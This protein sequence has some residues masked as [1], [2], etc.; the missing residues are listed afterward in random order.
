VFTRETIQAS[1]LS[2]DGK[3]FAV[4]HRCWTLAIHDVTNHT[5]N[6]IFEILDS[7][8]R[9]PTFS[10]DSSRF[11]AVVADRVIHIWDTITHNLLRKS[12][13]HSTDIQSLV[14]SPDGTRIIPICCYS[15]E[16]TL[17]IW[18]I[19]EDLTITLDEHG[20]AAAFFP[21]GMRFLT[22]GHNLRIWDMAST[23]IL[24]STLRASM[25]GS[26]ISISS[27]GA[28][29]FSD[30]CLWDLVNNRQI[31]S[32]VR[33]AT[34]VEFSP[35]CKLA[36][37]CDNIDNI[38]ILDA[39]TGAELYK[40]HLFVK[41][42]SHLSFSPDSTRLLSLSPDELAQVLDLK[43]LPT[44]VGTESQSC[45][46][47]PDCMM[48]QSQSQLQ[49]H[50]GWYHGASGDRL[51]WL[52]HNMRP[53]WLATGKQLFQSC[54]LFFGNGNDVMVLDVDDYLEVL[55]AGVAWSEAGIRYLEYPGLFDALMSTS[56][57]K[58]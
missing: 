51:I 24:V 5:D 33:H 37:L 23:P 40:S 44:F 1:A 9:L 21:D 56:G 35:D 10:P 6:V 53:V 48:I 49:Q 41:Y 52:P 2:P 58:V 3:Q 12:Q 15:P 43:S 55:P 26:C 34:K 46:Y 27:D 25:W 57:Y 17:Q 18:L 13:K 47:P 29:L 42:C 54:C 11:A 45:I 8:I 28:R 19:T 4:A 38:H 30:D 22:S 50:N 36:A 16:M 20:D 32:Y 14:I 31:S 7:P 39:T